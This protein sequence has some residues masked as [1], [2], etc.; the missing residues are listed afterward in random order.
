[1]TGKIE[2]VYANLEHLIK[3]HSS[4]VKLGFILVKFSSDHKMYQCVVAGSGYY[5]QI[6]SLDDKFG[7]LESGSLKNLFSEHFGTSTNFDSSLTADLDVFIKDDYNVLIVSD[8]DIIAGENL[9][10]FN[11]FFKRSG[12]KVYLIAADKDDYHSII[13][14][15]KNKSQNITHM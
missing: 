5:K 11:K 9:T 3:A 7:K 8:T 2:Q 12:D 14:A 13:G 1:M 15:L 6:K 4:E 10:E